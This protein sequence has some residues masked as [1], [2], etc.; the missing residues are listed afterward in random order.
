MASTPALVVPSADAST[1]TPASTTV[2]T[3][4]TS[5]TSTTSQLPSTPVSAAP[6]AVASTLLPAATQSP[7][8]STCAVY[9]HLCQRRRLS[10]RLLRL[11]C[12]SRRLLFS[13]R[14][15]HNLHLWM[16]HVRR[17]LRQWLLLQPIVQPRRWILPR[18]RLLW[19]LQLPR[20]AMV[21]LRHL[22]RLRRLLLLRQPLRLLLFSR[23]HPLLLLYV[24]YKPYV[25]TM[26]PHRGG[27]ARTIST[28]SQ[29]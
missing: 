12:R 5:T 22:N 4:P 3:V 27:C 28:A 13:L 1:P 16:V 17:R 25:R 10:C 24:S 14:Q 26:V 23:L 2:G 7:V 19:R 11:V 8:Q 9:S 21:H 29:K 18:R 6:V 20:L 15:P